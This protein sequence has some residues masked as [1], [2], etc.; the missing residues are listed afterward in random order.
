MRLRIL[1]IAA[2]AVALVA[3]AGCGAS[4]T[5]QDGGPRNGEELLSLAE[6]VDSSRMME[7]V[8]FMAGE[9]LKGRPSGSPEAAELAGFLEDSLRREGLE[10]V[11]AL[12]L[13]GYRQEFQIPSER[14]LMENP[15][16]SGQ[17]VTGANILGE[18][19]GEPGGEMVILTANYD[20]LGRDTET[21]AVFPGADFN[22]SGAAAVLELA[23]AFSS[24]GR[25][26]ASTLVFALLDGE[27][28]GNYGSRALAESIEAAGLRQAVRVINLEGLGGGEGDY[29]DVWD[30]NYR[31]NR[32]AVRAL[33][34]AAALLEVT[35]ELG[36]ADP[37][38][39]AGV[40]FLYHQPAVTCDWSWFDRGEHPDF[41][42]P[43]DTPDKINRDGMA[44][45]TRV[46]GLAAWT[47][48]NP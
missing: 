24:W 19:G 36:G 30:L 41:H 47:L 33:E 21:G 10:P 40:F 42:L 31:K 4:T 35:L 48:A 11:G 29:M 2:L 28:C 17:A 43:S 7:T 46:V 13:D 45:V 14:S 6:K 5:P 26:P 18:I 27:E 38:T 16:P 15:P 32:P 23:R 39:S 37:G 44:K 8:E 34:E 25:K 20:G 22:A 1:L 3:A 9:S 12:G